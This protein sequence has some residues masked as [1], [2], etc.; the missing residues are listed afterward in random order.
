MWVGLLENPADLAVILIC[1]RYPE[2]SSLGRA[3]ATA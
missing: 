2:V 1:E 3:R